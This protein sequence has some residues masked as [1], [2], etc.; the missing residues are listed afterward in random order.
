MKVLHVAES[1]RGGCGTYL[2]E[3]LSGLNDDVGAGSIRV[4]APDR[5]VKQL[6]DVPAAAIRSFRR[7]GRAFGLFFL[8]VELLAAV[9]EFRPDLIHAHST[10]AGAVARMLALIVPGMPPIVY[11]P[12]GWVFD[13]AR[14][15]GVRRRMEAIER[16]LS[17]WC[18]AIVAISEAEK[19]AGEAA[20]IRQGKMVVIQNG[21]RSS[22]PPWIAR[23][24]SDSRL[25]VLFVGRLDRQKGVDVLLEAVRPLEERVTVR[26]I[27]ESVLSNSAAPAGTRNVQYLGWLNQ[28]DVTAQ[29]SACDVVVMPSRWEGFGLV[30]IEAMRLAKPVIASR[31]G[32]LTDV[33]VDG[34]TGRLVPVGY[35]AA[36]REALFADSHEAR[37]RMGA[38]GRER[39]LSLYTIDR[40]RSQL[41]SLYQ[42]VLRSSPQR[43]VYINGRFLTQRVGGVQ[44]FAWEVVKALDDELS[45]SP[46][47][48]AERNWILLVPRG[49]MPPIALRRIAV[50]IVGDSSGHWWEQLVL[51]RAARGGVLVN[52]ANGA[53]VIHSRCVVVI[54]DAAV[55]RT[56]ENFAPLYVWVHRILGRLLSRTATLGTVSEFSRTELA[57][58]F[59][60]DPSSIFTVPNSCEHLR[61]VV[62]DEAVLE[63]LRVQA[64]HYFLFVG[65]P[66][67]NKN[68]LLAMAAFARWRRL[69]FRFVVV[70]V[71]DPAV[72]RKGFG[73]VPDGVVV[74]GHLPDAQV[75][76]L[77][78]SATALVFPSLYEGF[79]IPPLEGMVTGCPILAAR[80]PAVLEV[81]G[82]AA[83]Y[84]DP[85]DVDSLIAAMGSLADSPEAR[86]RL[87]EKGQ[88]R[89]KSFSWQVSAG[90]LIEAVSSLENPGFVRTPAGSR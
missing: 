22:P 28:E 57:S 80:I 42:A 2:N 60:L 19:L 46:S 45:R 16:L 85:R 21:I 41:A 18:V 25:K 8:A 64:N 71:A 72:L 70:G 68:L 56:P 77:L 34:V 6:P 9:R 36:L 7:P 48:L 84:F 82:D 11:C 67:P 23:A 13:T 1:I 61:D 37:S 15:R 88:E 50:K 24:W 33:I 90:R 65:K 81:C 79:G 69:G 29:I 53:P 78:K 20:G 58:I 17:R 5:H 39:F 44:R 47:G 74:A 59:R 87:I 62:P 49:H 43:D 4:L 63:R 51:P 54:H 66:S 76:A 30:A 3:L 12:H 86:R 83:M 89:A 31:I 10:F 75:V 73:E 26:I 38:A 14:S 52:L 55:F 32:G 27:G 35:A 40:T